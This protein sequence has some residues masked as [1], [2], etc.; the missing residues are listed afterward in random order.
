MDPLNQPAEPKRFPKLL[1]LA[2]VMVIAVVVYLN[3]GI[4]FV[5]KAP[6]VTQEG[7]ERSMAVFES[8]SGLA[9]SEGSS[10]ASVELGMVPEEL[11]LF[12][13]SSQGSITAR[14]ATSTGYYTLGYTSADDVL[15]FN[16]K[17]VEIAREQQF[18]IFKIFKNNLAAVTELETPNFNVRISEKAVD[19]QT[20]EISIDAQAK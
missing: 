8:R 5:E 11:L 17:L 4:L 6:P 3:K 10:L 14:S 16:T 13:I 7:V 20:T 15:G 9:F 2:V 18:N 12:T 1:L 19:E